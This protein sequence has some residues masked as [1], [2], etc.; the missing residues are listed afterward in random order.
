VL[1]PA[2]GIEHRAPST[3]HRA[4]R[5]VDSASVVPI[6]CPRRVDHPSPG[7]A[8][9]VEGSDILIGQ[10]D[11]QRGEILPPAAWVGRPGDD[12]DAVLA[13]EPGDRD[14]GGGGAMCCRDVPHDLGV[15]D[16]FAVAERTV[17]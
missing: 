6:R 17:R 11:V 10:V 4:P 5:C 8:Q 7:G 12:G 14:L 2:P 13:G 1:N 3:E 15:D 16:A 9:L